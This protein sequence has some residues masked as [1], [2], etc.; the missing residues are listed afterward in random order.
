MPNIFWGEAVTTAVYLLN[1]APTKSLPGK[2]PYE[3]FYGRKPN[4]A[5]L[6][7]FG[8]VG[9]VKKP[10]PHLTKL[11]DR[12]T[13]MVFIGYETSA[14]SKAYRMYD[15]VAKKVHIS[16]DVVF[17][18][19]RAW[20]WGNEPVG[21]NATSEPFVVEFSTHLDA[22]VEVLGDDLQET[23][24]ADDTDVFDTRINDGLIED[25]DGY[26][27]HYPELD[28]PELDVGDPKASP[29]TPVQA[30]PNSPR[31]PDAAASADASSESE[32]LRLRNVSS[33]YRDT[34]PIDLEYSGLCLLGIE[35]PTNFN[36]ANGVPSWRRAMEEELSS[37]N[38]NKTWTL[39]TLPAGHK[40]IGLKWVYKLNKDSKGEVLKHKARLVAKGYV[41]RRGIDFEEVFAP[42]ARLET[43]RLLIAIAAQ[44]GWQVHHMDVKSAF[45]NGDLVEEVY[46][47]QAPG[48]EKK[49]EEH[50]VLKLH[51]ALYGLRQAPRA[52]NSKL[53]K[54]LVAL[55]FEKCP[56]EHAV[57]KRG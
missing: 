18:E 54:S 52:W 39:T 12:S 29:A 34:V 17:E 15:P 24:N 5:H 50:K 31:T 14:H 45:L 56:L 16:R 55:G 40:A 47:A 13:K 33:I 44:E 20:A 22:G 53:D 9:H 27:D 38:D 46:V 25:G 35:E 32:P 42:V 6:R 23:D 2:T 26:A 37:I 21:G 8:C 30:A 10:T 19:E 36:E 3:A 43:V 7:T 48:F 1:R 28:Y 51:K 4:V 57:Y 49:G 41:Q 11:E